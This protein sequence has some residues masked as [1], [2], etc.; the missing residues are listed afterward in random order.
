MSN[1]A[2]NYTFRGLRLYD[3]E[4]YERFKAICRAEMTNPSRELNLFMKRTAELGYIPAAG[5]RHE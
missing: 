1:N 2:Y 4:V 3:A 5:A